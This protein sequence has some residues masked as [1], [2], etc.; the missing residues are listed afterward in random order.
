M[1]NLN[2]P[3]STFEVVEANLQDVERAAIVFDAYR[4]FYRQSSNIDAARNFLRQRLEEGTSMIYLAQRRGKEHG[5]PLETLGFAQLYPTFSSVSLKRVWI[6]NDLFVVPEVRGEG[7]G[8]LLLAH[9][10]TFAE[11]TQ[12]VRLTLQTATDNY[13][14]Q[15]VYEGMGWQRETSFFTYNL[16]LTKK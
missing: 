6:L 2:E 3:G 7:V 14:A 8:R 10:R 12:A 16:P 9:V 4:Q 11:E 5:E 13:R 1:V 15:S